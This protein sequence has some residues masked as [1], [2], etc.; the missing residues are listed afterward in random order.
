MQ[1]A[2]ATMNFAASVPMM[3]GSS[4]VGGLAGQTNVGM[5]GA[6]ANGVGSSQA[7]SGQAH[8]DMVRELATLLIAMALNK[9]DKEDKHSTVIMLSTSMLSANVSLN[10]DAGAVNGYLTASAGMAGQAM[11]GMAVNFSV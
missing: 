9:P 2:S 8:A 10:V 5:L 1:I 4:N 11:T 6:G 3:A 7:V